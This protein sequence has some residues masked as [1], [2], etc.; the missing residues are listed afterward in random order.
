MEKKS[1]EVGD[2]IY[3]RSSWTKQLHAKMEIERVTKTLGVAGKTR[4]E[5]EYCGR[6][7]RLKGERTY[8]SGDSYYVA[9]EELKVEFERELLMS[10]ANDV[11][12]SQLPNEL[13]KKIIEAGKIT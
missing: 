8:Y 7:P 4:F 9:T 2:I 1:L 11:K 12:M 3:A 10:K 5:R 6:G 13:L